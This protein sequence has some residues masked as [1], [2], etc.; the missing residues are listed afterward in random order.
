LNKQAHYRP[1]PGK[2]ATMG[3][4]PVEPIVM[5]I[6]DRIHS[7]RFKVFSTCVEVFEEMRN[8]HRDDKGKIVAK[9]DDTFKAITYGMMML[10]YARQPGS[11]NYNNP[12]RRQSILK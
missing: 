8:L 1:E 11:V 2:K 3:G 12:V 9:M 4:Q 10:R 7:G 6:I 5:E